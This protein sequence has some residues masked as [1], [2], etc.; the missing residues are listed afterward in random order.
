METYDS[1][2]ETLEHIDRVRHF[3]NR[4]ILNITVRSK[5]HD[6]TKLIEPE[7][8]AFDIATPKLANLK[9]GSDEYKE[10]LKELGSAL[11]HHYQHNDHH[12]QYFHNGV[13]GMSLMSL[14][15][16]LCD[17]RAASERTKQH[18]DDPVVM[19]TFEAGIEFSIGRFHIEPQLA[20]ILRNT[21]RELEM[22]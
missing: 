12:P 10:S 9:Y 17:W 11:E 18:T 16:M 2:P 13:E 21:A 8:S 22:Y 5:K 7:K 14:L 15:E 20:Q 3:I 19:N 1:S 6:A 4:A